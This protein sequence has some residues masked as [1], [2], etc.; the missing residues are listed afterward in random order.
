MR[1][2]DQRTLLRNQRLLA[3]AVLRRYRMLPKGVD[4]SDLVFDGIKWLM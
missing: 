2:R 1:F 4:L 3:C